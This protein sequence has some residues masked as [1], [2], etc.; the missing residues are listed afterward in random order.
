VETD[1]LIGST[2]GNYT[3]EGRLGSGGMGDVYRGVQRIAGARVAVKILHAVVTRDVEAAKRFHV[4]AQAGNRIEHPGVIKVIDAGLLRDGRPYLVMPL[5]EGSSLADH[6]QGTP[7]LPVVEACGI[8]IDVLDAVGAAHAKGFVHRDLKPPNVFLTNEGRVVIL[9]FG[10]AKL[11]SSDSPAR[12]TRTGTAIG[13]PYYMAPEQIKEQLVGPPSDVY[14]VG[15]VLFEMLCGRLPFEGPSAFEVMAGHLEKRP[16]PPRAL[17]PDIPIPVQEVILSALAKKPE[18]RFTNAGAMRDALRTASGIR[19]SQTEPPR[20]VSNPNLD[21]SGA[22]AATLRRA[23][24]PP[25][26]DVESMPTLRRSAPELRAA[27]SPPAAA[28]E[29]AAARGIGFMRVLPWL[30]AVIALVAAAIVLVTKDDPPAATAP[31]EDAAAPPVDAAAVPALV[32]PVSDAAP[33]IPDAAPAR[34]RPRPD[35]SDLHEDLEDPFG[36]DDDGLLEPGSLSHRPDARAQVEGTAELD[37]DPHGASV[38]VDGSLVGT[39]PMTTWLP[40]GVHHVEMR[41]HG[42]ATVAK[43]ID[44]RSDSV[45]VVRYVLKPVPF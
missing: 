3:L 13:T 32:A 8:A 11:M 10:V 27:P 2:A 29:P 45:T 43:D 19:G 5:L 15:V 17:R 12:L 18:R 34:M 22:L 16:P 14:A 23:A 20:T 24:P 30:V 25:E 21:A 6:L 42:F 7:R 41:L 9:D 39:T 44:V 31:A 40:V 37:S 33:A 1:P 36:K 28:P 4:E 26:N 38:F 35:A